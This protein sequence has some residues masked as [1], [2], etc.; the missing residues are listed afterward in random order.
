MRHQIK[1]SDKTPFKHR[2]GPIHPNDL[3]AVRK[4]LLELQQ[5]GVICET[6]SPFS[7]PIMVVRKRNGDVHLFID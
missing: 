5:A 2:A 4:H 3:E 1:L 7:S 6:S